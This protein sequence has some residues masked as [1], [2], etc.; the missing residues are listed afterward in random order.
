MIDNKQ[1]EIEDAVPGFYDLAASWHMVLSR[2]YSRT[3]HYR[4]KRPAE[5]N[6]VL[7]NL[8]SVTDQDHILDMGCGQGDSV[9][10]LTRHYKC[11]IEAI[12]ISVGEVSR[13]KRLILKEKCTDRANVFLGNMLRVPFPDANFSLV[14]AIE[15]MCHISDKRQLA[16]ESYRLLRRGGRMVMADFFLMK[17]VEGKRRATDYRNFCGGFIVPSLCSKD[18]FLSA[19]SAVGFRNVRYVDYSK[20]IRDCVREREVFGWV[21]LLLIFPFSVLKILPALF[22]QNSLGMIAQGRLFRHNVI[23][24]GVIYAEK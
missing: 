7:A 16:R 3:L 22:M 1:R 6:F 21:N 13:V 12:T 4:M 20:T 23:S 9:R 11:S 2:G 10:W 8:A 24:Y 5:T 18:E 17:D 15:S 14:W 19:L